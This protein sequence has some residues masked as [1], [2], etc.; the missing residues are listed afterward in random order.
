MTD[1]PLWYEHRQF[2]IKHLRQL[3]LGKNLMEAMILD[4]FLAFEKHLDS[5]VYQEIQFS[6]K[7]AGSV[8]NVLWIMVS[9]PN[10]QKI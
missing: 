1:G 4:E 10:K 5:Q 9:R 2:L 6:Q 3:G 7:V 8:L